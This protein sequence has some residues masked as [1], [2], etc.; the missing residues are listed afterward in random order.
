MKASSEPLASCAH[1]F[2]TALP[3]VPIRPTMHKSFLSLRKF[4]SS[5]HDPSSVAAQQGL[6]P[7][8]ALL[9]RVDEGV[10]RGTRRGAIQRNQSAPN[11][12][13]SPPSGMCLAAV[14]YTHLR[15]H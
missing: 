11:G 9:R 5:P 15:A 13:P 10:A 6:A 8:G 7:D 1:A 14:S 12:Q 2:A 3:S 4:S